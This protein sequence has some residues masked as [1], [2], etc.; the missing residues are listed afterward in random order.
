[1][2]QKLLI[3]WISPMKSKLFLRTAHL[4]CCSGLPGLRMNAGL[5]SSL[6]AQA[7]RRVV[8]DLYPNLRLAADVEAPVELALDR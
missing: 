6:Q 5:K 8:A 7:A 2:P 1:M 3:N 4:I